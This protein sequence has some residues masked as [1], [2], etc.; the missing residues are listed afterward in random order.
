M[1]GVIGNH[2]YALANHRWIEGVGNVRLNS[3]PASQ[4]AGGR[5]HGHTPR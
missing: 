2:S 3:K 5:S 1:Q 4:F